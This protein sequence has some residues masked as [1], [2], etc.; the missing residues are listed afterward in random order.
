M[1]IVTVLVL[2]SNAQFKIE[3][4]GEAR[5]WSNNMGPWDNSMITYANNNLSKAY[6]VSR[7]SSHTF[8]VRGDGYVIAR[9]SFINSDKNLKKDIKNVENINSLFLLQA[10]TYKFI[11][12]QD[13]TALIFKR[14]NGE[15][16]DSI[17]NDSDLK[18]YGFIAQEVMEVYP[19]LVSEDENG[20]LSINYVAFVPLIIEA[21][22]QQKEQIETLQK[23]VYSQEIEFIK[24]KRTIESCCYNENKSKLKS[25]SIYDKTTSMDEIISENAKLFDN[26]PNPF[27]LN[28]EI[29]FEIPE[30]SSSA[31]LIIHDMQGIELK[32]FDI[33][34]KGFGSVSISGS[35]LKA[36]MYLYTLL[37]DNKIIDTKRMLLT[38]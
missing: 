22:K 12:K 5:L 35:E 17:S 19:E 18:Q 32:S 6:V 15:N 31:K 36:G 2:N 27:S 13:S 37:I 7:N 11:S 10:K 25:S 8:Y 28:T 14:I 33:S 29:R 26:A 4:N 21:A 1:F 23:I 34:Q 24:L 16:H 3:S 30:S 20:L 38:K 9:G